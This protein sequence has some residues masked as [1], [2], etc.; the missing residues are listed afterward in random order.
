MALTCQP[1]P[2]NTTTLLTLNGLEGG[3]AEIGIYGITGVL[4]KTLLTKEGK[5][6]WDATDNS[7]RKVSSGIYFAGVETQQKSRAIKLVYLK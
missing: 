7:G 1:N 4:V 5:A 3:D 2:F 6:A